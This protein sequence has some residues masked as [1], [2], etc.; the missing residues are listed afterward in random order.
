MAKLT[1]QKI[2]RAMSNARTCIATVQADS[3]IVHKPLRVQPKQGHMR[4]ADAHTLC[5]NMRDRC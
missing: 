1:R 2:M 5:Q 4:Q 3:T